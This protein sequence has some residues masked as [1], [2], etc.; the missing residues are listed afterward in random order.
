MPL[1]FETRMRCGV[2]ED[3]RSEADA[4]L[5][6][7]G[8][9][10]RDA[11]RELDRAR[12]QRSSTPPARRGKPGSESPLVVTEN[13]DG[14]GAADL[15][16]KGGEIAV[17]VLSV[18]VVDALHRA[19]IEVVRSLDRRQ[20]FARSRRG[21]RQQAAGKKTGEAS[22]TS[23]DPSM[24][25]A[26]RKGRKPQTSVPSRTIFSPQ[27][28][29][30]A[31]MDQGVQVPEVGVPG[32]WVG[33][34]LTSSGYGS[35]GLPAL[36]VGEGL[37]VGRQ[38]ADRLAG[39]VRIAVRRI[40][41][42]RQMR[43]RLDLR[44]GE[45]RRRRGDRRLS[46]SQPVIVERLGQIA[47]VVVR[48]VGRTQIRPDRDSSCRA[49]GRAPRRAAGERHEAVQLVDELDDR[50]VL[51][52]AMRDRAGLRRRARSG[53]SGCADRPPGSSRRRTC[54]ASGETWS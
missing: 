52:V 25:F 45:R 47:D 20:A 50:P 15:A 37:E 12:L 2:I 34:G 42:L 29:P 22:E 3:G 36:V 49:C 19:A 32:D 39:A 33:R 51:A 1:C 53:A 28:E 38:D 13:G 4:E 11:D 44:R 21:E 9:R 18:P 14:D 30:R 23:T 10:G 17:D 27:A 48:I 35:I 8:R 46:P 41:R 31:R 54:C 7:D 24:R 5:H 16:S 6:G 40:V 43:Q 26:K